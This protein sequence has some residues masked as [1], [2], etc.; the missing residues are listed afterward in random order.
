MIKI[1][2]IFDWQ[3]YCLYMCLFLIVTA[4][5]SEVFFLPFLSTIINSFILTKEINKRQTTLA[6]TNGKCLTT[7]S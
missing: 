5:L 1:V 3:V 7:S 4:R 2:Y 6:L